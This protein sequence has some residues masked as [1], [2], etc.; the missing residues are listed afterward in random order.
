MPRTAATRLPARSRASGPR[1]GIPPPT[2]GLEAE[3]R[4][5][6]AGDRLELRPVMGEHVLVRR[7]DRHARRRAPP[8]SASGPAPRRPSARRR[9]R[10]LRDARRWAGA[11]VSSSAG[12]PRRAAASTSRTAIPDSSRAGR[13]ST[14]SS[15]R[16]SV[17]AR[18]TSRPDRARAENGD[19]QHLP[20]HRVIVAEGW[21]RNPVARRA[22]DAT[23]PARRRAPAH[24]L[25]LPG[26]LAF[27]VMAGA[28]R[29]W[30]AASQRHNSGIAVAEADTLAL[31]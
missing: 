19:P 30:P 4:A 2:D 25:S 10:R 17:S 18:M 27:T 14:A 21:G 24:G 26:I 3:R 29:P 11:S 12:S 23:K 6:P 1:T 9:R 16:R 22:P 28:R 31:P 7:H 20:A 15:S 8:R 13:P 5:G